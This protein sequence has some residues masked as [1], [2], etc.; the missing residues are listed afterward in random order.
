M[1]EKCI[2]PIV[3]YSYDSFPSISINN[4]LDEVTIDGVKI[5]DVK[6]ENKINTKENLKI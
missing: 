1:H 5:Y 2:F 3:V 6:L 4:N